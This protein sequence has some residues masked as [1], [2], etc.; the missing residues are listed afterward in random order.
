MVA[1]PNIKAPKVMPNVC[2]PAVPPIFVLTNPTDPHANAGTK[3]SKIAAFIT[4][5]TPSYL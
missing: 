1:N 3:A 5:K 2:C 4:D